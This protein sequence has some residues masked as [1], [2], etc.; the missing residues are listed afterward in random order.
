MSTGCLVGLA[1]DFRVVLVTFRVVLR[2]NV[3][4]V[5]FLYEGQGVGCCRGRCRVAFFEGYPCV[6]CEHASDS[7]FL[8]VGAVRSRQ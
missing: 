1:S 8:T 5:T 6:I 2:D 3:K 4:S 7:K